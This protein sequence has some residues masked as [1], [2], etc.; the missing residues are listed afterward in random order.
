MSAWSLRRQLTLWSTLVTSLALLTLGA[1]TAIGLYFNQRHVIE[2]QLRGDARVFFNELHEHGAPNPADTDDAQRLLDQAGPPLTGFAF[3]PP[4]G[5]PTYFSPA[6]F[7]PVALGPLPASG[8]RSVTTSDGR[9]LR[10]GVFSDT[11]ATL[12]LAADLHPATDLV[13]DLLVIGLL[14]LPVEILVIALGS[15]WIARQAL[16]PIARITAA[17]SAIEAEKLRDRL[18]LPATDDEIGQHT[19]VLNAMFDR[20]ER[21]FEQATRFTADASHELRTPLTILRGE[22]E[23]A[24]RTAAPGEHSETL[25]MGLLE[26]TGRLQRIADN[27][28]LLAQFD[29]GKASADFVEVELSA[30]VGDAAED[31]SLLAAPRE[32]TVGAAI[33]PGLRVRGDETLLRRLLLN[34]VD[35]ATRYNRPGGRVDIALRPDAGRV[36]LT[37][38]NTGPWIPEE[39][40]PGIFQRFF[41]LG[42]QR[43]RTR[44]GSG[45]GLSLCR[46]I[47][48][49]HH[50]RIELAPGRPDWTEFTVILPAIA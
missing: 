7:A 44:G 37:V 14:A 13:L 21:S 10:I 43:D 20:L 35:N 26:Q 30:V 18:P 2:E 50:G 32:L 42:P 1:G 12:V 47:A 45:L 39:H 25:L 34:L 17:A 38:A 19:R 41:R 40:R 48:L 8:Y 31:A 3:G 11:D 16:A 5:V 36:V 9:R 23:Q 46:E 15:N 49:T 22:I 27:L 29:A 24:L 4:H 33:T 6:S 28:L